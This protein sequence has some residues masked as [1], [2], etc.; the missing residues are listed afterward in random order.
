MMSKLRPYR[1][2]VDIGYDTVYRF[3]NGHSPCSNDNEFKIWLKDANA[4]EVFYPCVK[5]LTHGT[6][7]HKFVLPY[8]AERIK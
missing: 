6:F 2:Y 8:M 4:L 3:I 1:W 5:R 7:P